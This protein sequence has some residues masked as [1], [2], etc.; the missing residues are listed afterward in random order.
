MWT[1]G[2]RYLSTIEEISKPLLKCNPFQD[3]SI[4]ESKDNSKLSLP[5]LQTVW[6]QASGSLEVLYLSS[7]PLLM[8]PETCLL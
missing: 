2:A 3:M 6:K 1:L 5:M 8:A 4:Q 7:V